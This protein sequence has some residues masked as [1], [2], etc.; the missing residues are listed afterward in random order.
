MKKKQ[1]NENQKTFSD[2]TN[3]P[4]IT[5]G[6]KI[7]YGDSPLEIVLEK[8]KILDVK[9]ILFG[10]V[11]NTWKIVITTDDKIHLLK[12]TRELK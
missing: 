3:K 7:K 12:S 6:Q 2:L 9:E 5:E 1:L 11:Y 10:D 4:W 8:T